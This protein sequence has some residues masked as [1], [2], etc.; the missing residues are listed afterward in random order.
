ME[1]IDVYGLAQLERILAND[2]L[3][4]VFYYGDNPKSADL[5]AL[6]T[7]I[8][9]HDAFDNVVLARI[10]MHRLP[11]EYYRRRGVI[12][13]PTVCYFHGTHEQGRTT[14]MQTKAMLLKSI[15]RHKTRF[16]ESA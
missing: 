4:V 5:H 7:Q 11:E 12:A 10:N 13:S 3:T 16:L 14:G 8:A 6:F 2:R 15:A 9:N 1:I